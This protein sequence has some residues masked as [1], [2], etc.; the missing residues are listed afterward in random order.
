MSNIY[1]QKWFTEGFRYSE[2]RVKGILLERSKVCVLGCTF[3]R[4]DGRKVGLILFAR[5]TYRTI[6]YKLILIIDETK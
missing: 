5:I 4:I 3:V 2:R 6:T 1:V